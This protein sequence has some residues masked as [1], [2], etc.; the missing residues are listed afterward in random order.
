MYS[1]WLSCVVWGKK[2]WNQWKI[3]VI[4]ISY[5]PGLIN[6]LKN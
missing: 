2:Y 1:K 6:G 4:N 3:K 5:V